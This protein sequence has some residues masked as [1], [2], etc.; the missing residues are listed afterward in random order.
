M[1][2][3]VNNHSIKAGSAAAGS[4]LEELF[5]IQTCRK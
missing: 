3:P 5:Q 1:T 2:D 4:L